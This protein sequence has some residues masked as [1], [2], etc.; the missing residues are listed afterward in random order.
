M[1][2]IKDRLIRAMPKGDKGDGPQEPREVSGWALM[3]LVMAFVIAFAL[4][5]FH[6][7]ILWVP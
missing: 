2:D 5:L 3:I 6:P 1:T 7:S 4:F